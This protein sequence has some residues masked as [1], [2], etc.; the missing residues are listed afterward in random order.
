MNAEDRN[1]ETKVALDLGFDHVFE[2]GEHPESF[3]E[4]LSVF[5]DSMTDAG[6]WIEEKYGKRAAA[7]WSRIVECVDQMKTFEK[8]PFKK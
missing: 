4:F 7:S 6:R 5:G 2:L 1:H 8:F 3:K